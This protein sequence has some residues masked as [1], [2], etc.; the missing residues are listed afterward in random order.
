MFKAA[1]KFA[2]LCLAAA[3]LAAQP[4]RFHRGPAIPDYGDVA[5]VEGAAPIPEGSEFRVAFD[6]AQGA[7]AGEVNRTLD[8]AARFINMHV[9]AGVPAE[10]IHLAV[11]VHGRAAVDLTRPEFYAAA[12]DGAA[13]AN[14]A[15]V[16]ALR[17]HGVEFYVCGQSA[18]YYGIGARDL[19]PG[20]EMALSAMT[21]HALLQQ[22][23]YTLNPF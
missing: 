8:S 14:A 7:E 4:E 21:A 2:A 20:V 16:D 18:A 13:N 12:Q 3:P 19:L 9:E 22:Q 15:L 1:F 23:G 11:V 6:T 10:N 5:A 17:A